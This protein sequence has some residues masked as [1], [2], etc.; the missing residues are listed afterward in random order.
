MPVDR[1][2]FREVL[3]LWPTG[4]GVVTTAAGGTRHGMT[5]SSLSSVSVEPPLVSVCVGRRQQTHRLIEASRNFAVSILA[6]DQVRLGRAFAGMEPAVGDRFGL[7]RWKTAATGAPVLADAVAWLDCDVEHAYPGGDHTIFVGRVRS[8]SRARSVAPLLYHSRAWGQ[9]AEPLPESVDVADVGLAEALAGRWAAP[10]TVESLTSAVRAAGART[11]ISLAAAPH[12]PEAGPT[13]FRTALVRDPADV[14]EALA[15]GVGVIEVSP[16]GG[17]TPALVTGARAHGLD[18]VVRVPHAFA[19]G[20]ADRVRAAIEEAL[21]LDCAE[22]CLEEGREAASPLHV[23]AVV[24]DAVV[25][26]RPTPVRVA[27]REHNGL[28]MANAL[29]AMKSGA[30]LFDTTLGGVDGR[31][32]TEDLL[33]LAARLGVAST[34]DRTALMAAA[35]ELRQVW[36]AELP[37]RTAHMAP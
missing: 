18:V 7:G 14:T 26:S 28:G 4:V 34:A 12:I 36:G 30:W 25:R 3:G 27:L 22:L 35:D 29:T 6:R 13:P 5:A 1:D 16:T 17:D 24:Q 8:A 20:A 19:E 10:A 15:R 23:R 31:L 2:V 37:A 32:P 9:I 21:D 11:R 33:Y